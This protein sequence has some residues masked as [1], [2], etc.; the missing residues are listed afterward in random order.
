[1][2]LRVEM[3]WR[4]LDGYI[5]VRVRVKV[6]VYCPD[7]LADVMHHNYNLDVDVNAVQKSEK[8][9]DKNSK[10][11]FL[12]FIFLSSGLFIFIFHCALKE[13]VQKQW[14]RY[15]C[16]GR[17]RLSD[18]SGICLPACL[19]LCL[20]VSGWSRRFTTEQW[21]FF[22]SLYRSPVKS[23]CRTPARFPQQQKKRR[24][25]IKI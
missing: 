25:F 24:H 19:S 17:F 8:G 6:T 22:T 18:N 11:D 2:G 20:F 15:L 13:N 14:R 10:S 7:R 23:V 4:R 12:I 3:E 5:V 9:F 21:S 1:M 16:C